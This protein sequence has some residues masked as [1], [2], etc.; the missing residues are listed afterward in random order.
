M[1]SLEDQ[2]QKL[3]AGRKKPR[4]LNLNGQYA[5]GTGTLFDELINLAGGQNVASEV[6]INGF[7]IFADELLVAIDP[8]VIVL[9]VG[10]PDNQSTDPRKALFCKPSWQQLSAVRKQRVVLLP[11]KYLGSISHYVILGL[12][13]LAAALHPDS[14]N[15]LNKLPK[16][17]S[18][19]TP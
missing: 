14:A 2:V 11:S 10:D 19:E 8:D 12:P 7:G 9:V 6:G 18:V 15:E 5:T 17:F 3:V 16:Q 4:V 1:D 13:S